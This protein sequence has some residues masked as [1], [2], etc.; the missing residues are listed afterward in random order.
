ME[1]PMWY[2]T[3]ALSHRQKVQRLYKRALRECD[4]WYGGNLLEVRYQKVLLRARF[5]ATTDER[6]PRKSQLLL[7]DGCRE[8]WSKRHMKPFRFQLDPGGS[9]FDRD[10]ESPDQILDW[11][12]W[13]NA[14]R[15]QFPY[16]FNKR[17]ERKKE[18]LEHWFKI[19][20][21]WDEELAAIQRE[22][23]KEQSAAV[24]SGTP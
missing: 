13:T 10:R 1:S 24:K 9:S 3:K 20:K 18:L 22:L 14:E 8:L 16:Y 17:E 2:F 19:E 23:P 5:D 4:S 11:E 7:A 6:D 21:A 15:E 12:Q